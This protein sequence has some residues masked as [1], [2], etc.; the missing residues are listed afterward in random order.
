MILSIMIVNYDEGERVGIKLE[1][2][3]LMGKS[4]DKER[5]LNIP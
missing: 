4:I 5:D 2:V 3:R 1:G